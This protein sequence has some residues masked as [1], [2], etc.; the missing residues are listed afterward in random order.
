[1]SQSPSTPTSPISP[2]AFPFLSLTTSASP[3]TPTYATLSFHKSDTIRLLNFPA[4]LTAAL[5]PIL[6]ASWPPGIQAQ[7]QNTTEQSAE[8]KFRGKPFGNSNSQE[9]V[10]GLRLMR[11]ILSAL[12]DSGW[13][14]VTSVMCSKRVTAKDTLIFRQRP[15]WG[16]ASHSGAPPLEWLI[17]APMARD[18]L[19]VV[20]DAE[21]IRPH[22]EIDEE[23]SRDY[24]GVLVSGIKK[25]LNALGLFEKGNWSHDSFEMHLKGNPWRSR[26]EASVTVRILLIKLF[27]LV[28][29]HGW[30]TYMTLVQRTGDDEERMPDTWY[31]VR[32]RKN[33]GSTRPTTG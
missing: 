4:T 6:L 5:E 15:G 24:L 29:G 12:H 23:Q 33:T 14:L 7:S 30:R 18:K 16:S 28:E 1:M 20:Y 21:G 8:F 11:N 17:L 9:G 32:E 22:G 2:D 13:E 26:G 27:E 10:G 25:V 19:R 3:S 31:F